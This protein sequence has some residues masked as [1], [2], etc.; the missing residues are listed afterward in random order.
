MHVFLRESVC[1]GLR[2]K[3]GEGHTDGSERERRGEVLGSVYTQ[4]KKEHTNVHHT[5]AHKHT[6]KQLHTPHCRTA[7]QEHKTHSCS[8]SG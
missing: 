5:R 8:C 1:V 3:S 4:D 6:L 7:L 2:R